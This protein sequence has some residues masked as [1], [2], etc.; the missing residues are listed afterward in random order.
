MGVGPV[1]FFSLW[2]SDADGNGES[3]PPKR[4]RSLSLDQGIWIGHGDDDATDTGAKDFRNTRRSSFLE[5][6]T[7]LERHIEGSALGSAAGLSKRENFRMRQAWTK[8]KSLPDDSAPFDHQGT[9]HRIGTSR[10]PALRRQAKGQ[11]HIVEILLAL[12]HRLLRDATLTLAEGRGDLAADF[13]ASASAN[14]AC[15]AAS[16][17]I[18]TR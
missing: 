3:G 15:A 16:L 1:Q 13:F 4:C 17:A 2:P 6:T 8:M 9:D 12:G 5:V 7:G 14:A 10:T 11:S 18:A